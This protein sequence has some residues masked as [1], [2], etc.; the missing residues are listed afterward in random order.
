VNPASAL[1]LMKRTLVL[2]SRGAGNTHPNPMVGAVVAADGRIVGEGWHRR[3]GEP[4][5]EALALEEA[6]SAARGGVLFV[7][8]E[9]C[10][11]VGRTAP[12]TKAII[13][14]GITHVFAAC[15]DPHFLV[16]GKG[17]KTLREAGVGVTTGTLGREAEELNRA[18]FH[19][20]REGTPYITLKLASTMDGRIAA[21]DGDSKWITGEKARRAVHR[22]RAQVDAVMVGVGT[23]IADDPKLTA[24]DVGRKIQPMRVVL[25]PAL[26]TPPGSIIVRENQ[27]G[28]TLLVI[29]EEVPEERYQA[30]QDKGVRLLRLPVEEGLFAW[31]ALAGS[32][33]DMGILHVLAEGGGKTAAW[34][35]KTGAVN[36]LELFLA[37]RVL[38]ASGIPAVGDMGITSMKEAAR[39]SFHRIRRI[40]EDVQITADV[41]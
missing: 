9:P 15:G 19:F 11:H 4:H 13:D 30:F 37:A 27:A 2:A 20:S 17:F 12:C 28:S 36:R 35:L 29:G 33:A 5:A 40:G 7:N 8:L 25:D 22:L 41:K 6:G 39:L 3:P 10:D 31:S 23:V 16:D 38:G 21:P 14:A 24:R 18:F 1:K 26:R 32:L 34:M